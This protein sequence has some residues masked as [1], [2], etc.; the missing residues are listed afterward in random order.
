MKPPLFVACL[1]V[2]CCGA[3]I[4]RA[5]PITVNVNG[6]SGP[7]DT[8]LN[9]AYG[10]GVAVGGEDN[11]NA[12]PEVV[13]SSSGLPLA[14]GD[15]LIIVAVYSPDYVPTA[16]PYSGGSY[17]APSPFTP[18]LAGAYGSYWSNADGLGGY[19]SNGPGA[20]GFYISTPTF[21]EELVG[22]FTSDGVIVGSPFAIG[23]GPVSEVIPVGANE[24][25]LG[26]NDAWYNDN[27]GGVNVSITEISTAVPDGAATI[28]M[29]EIG[30]G[31]MVLLRV[32][33]MLRRS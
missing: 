2:A 29:L 22:V 20:P 15:Q 23:N 8:S 27:G 11:V 32:R 28:L 30:F 3:A 4:S 9:P 14:A 21:L 16:T 26:I 18:L 25:S 33:P 19:P 7:W 13:N 5:D 12:A 6:A 10:Y 24:L 17:G 1:A 31:A